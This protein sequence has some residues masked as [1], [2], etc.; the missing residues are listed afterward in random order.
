MVAFS[1]ILHSGSR[2]QALEKFVTVRSLVGLM[3]RIVK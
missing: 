1:G 3:D 2:M